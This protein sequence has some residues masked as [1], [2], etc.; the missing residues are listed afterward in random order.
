MGAQ[1]PLGDGASS[2]KNRGDSPFSFTQT[3]ALLYW[4]RT[5]RLTA[6]LAK[7]PNAS[8]DA[9]AFVH[10][11]S[12][13]T[14]LVTITDLETTQQFI[15]RSKPSG[16]LLPGAHRIDREYR[17]LS[18]LINTPV[19]TP[20]P[21][22]YCEDCSVLGVEFYIMSYASGI[23]FK[24]VSLTALSNPDDR[25]QVFMEAL[26]ILSMIRSLD[27]SQLGLTTLSRPTP[28][29]ADK[30]IDTWYHQYRASR[31]D[32]ID[33][34]HMELL[35]LQLD[36]LRFLETH[37]EDV[38][39]LVHG[40]FRIDNLVFN[41]ID[42]RLVCTAVLDWEL[43]ALGNPLADLASLLTPYYLPPLAKSIPV[44]R[45]TTF[46]HI[47]PTGIPSS[48]H[49]IAHYVKQD[50]DG[51]TKSRKYLKFYVAVALF[52]FGAIIYG[53]L[54]RAHHGNAASPH[55]LLL[56]SHAGIFAEA[57]LKLL[58][59][60][61][62]DH[63]TTSG[64]LSP[65]LIETL[66]RFMDQEVLPLEQDFIRHTQSDNRWSVWAPIENLKSKAKDAGLWN[67]FLPKALGG[68]LTTEEYAPLAENM[69]RCVY[70]A[71]VFNCSAPDTG[72]S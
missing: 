67:L 29:W 4:L 12:N 6:D 39:C 28:S 37:K 46:D 20:E 65:T 56:G 35:H 47:K 21:Y 43:V 69:G 1:L 27:I 18:A 5:V 64:A 70:A 22:A 71:E 7:A 61:E 15:L 8:L 45:S 38:R 2:T 36:K 19:P 72:E 30:Q 9:S 63:S 3:R 42:G 48:E 59:T 32:D 52:R 14:Y 49:L 33:Y 11:Q 62:L 68:S 34:S 41:R 10:G 51:G 23:I 44:L 60:L 57:G 17:V 25:T 40:D 24:D 53:V 55:A 31:L 54:Y 50:S 58:K 16:N 66:V 13:P 26:H